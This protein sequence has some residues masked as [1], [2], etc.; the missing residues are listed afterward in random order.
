MLS[1]VAQ[2]CQFLFADIPYVSALS[3]PKLYK[4]QASIWLV[5]F[6]FQTILCALLI[7]THP[8]KLEIGGRRSFA[9]RG[10]PA[11]LLEELQND[12][13]WGT[14]T[15]PLT[16][17]IILAVVNVLFFGPQ[18]QKYITKI[19]LGMWLKRPSSRGGLELKI[20]ADK[21]LVFTRQEKAG[22]PAGA[23][24]NELKVLRRKL[25]A[26]HVASRVC[27]MAALTLTIAYA[28]GLDQR[29]LDEIA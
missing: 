24:S 8:Y 5:Y 6:K 15:V 1:L 21:S 29:L 28:G 26:H 10:R 16:G 22:G 11:S 19:H 27:D 3:R 13:N 12:D 2:L 20:H 14:V 7:W 25:V 4:L 18:T 9:L 23:D 17:M